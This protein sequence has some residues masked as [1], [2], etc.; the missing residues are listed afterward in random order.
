MN[1][2]GKNPDRV[3][4]VIYAKSLAQP[5]V[6]ASL[7]EQLRAQTDSFETEVVSASADIVRAV[8]E[9]SLTV[10][11]V[12]LHEKEELVEILNALVQLE[13][14]IQSGVLRSIVLNGLNHPRVATLLKA[15]NASDILPFSAPIKTLNHKIKNSLLLVTQAQERL[16]SRNIDTATIPGN[17]SQTGAEVRSLSDAEGESE[18]EYIR[19]ESPDLGKV[20]IK[21]SLETNGRS[22]LAP[23]LVI[24]GPLGMADVTQAGVT[25]GTNSFDRL[26]LRVT[27][28]LRNGQPV[29]PR[30]SIYVMEMTK[31]G[32]SFEYP[33]NW[34]VEKDKFML[35]V[36]FRLG[37]VER[38]FEVEWLSQSA[39]M[40][41]G[42]G[43]LAH[44]EFTGGA[45][46][47]LVSMVTLIDQ[48]QI[49]LR[50][51]FITA[52]GA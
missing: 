49:E 9:T 2:P 34:I 44:G 12:S 18:P 32:A 3:K 14:R 47:E 22:S 45:L 26:F 40:I 7:V 42:G 41:D 1:S 20:K 33:R 16:Q 8:E 25:A 15:K 38:N 39:E 30:K 52:R 11:I 10:L 13:A 29:L 31:K 48:R 19:I 43:C 6:M 28:S 17:E 37:N 35:R 24:G 50:D 23:D 36:E 51:F 21:A 4:I 5:P 46:A 27:L